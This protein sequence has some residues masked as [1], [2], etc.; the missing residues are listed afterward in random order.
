LVQGG[1]AF[2]AS[3]H[4]YLGGSKDR[5]NFWGI[6]SGVVDA[7]H[8][9]ADSGLLD[10][11]LPIDIALSDA[12]GPGNG[13]PFFG[14]AA[15]LADDPVGAD[16]QLPSE[17]W[18]ISATPKGGWAANA[19]DQTLFRLLIIVA[20]A[21]VLVPLLVAGRLM[22][23]RQS[24]IR[25]LGDREEQLETL[26]R[27]LGLALDTS[28]IGVWEYH[29][30]R[31]RLV[32]DDRM[33]ELYGLPSDGGPRNYGHWMKALHPDDLER[34]EQ[35]FAA[36][37]EAGGQYVSE[38]RVMMPGNKVRHIRAIG[39][40]Y[41]DAI[42]TSRIVGV[43][44]DV[45]ADF[46]LNAELKRVNSLTEARNVE[47][48][49]ATARIERNALHDAL[50]GLPNRR[51][52]D[53]VLEARSQ[54]SRVHGGCVALLHIDLDRFKQI[55]DTLG[56]AAGDAMLIHAAEVLRANVREDDFIGRIGGD[57]FVVVVN[58]LRK[59]PKYLAGLADRIITDMR[60]PVP[61]QGH[62]CRFGVSVGIAYQR[63]KVIDGKRLLVDADIALYRAKSQ[64][65]NRYEFFTDAL[66]AEIFNS[67]RIA[68]EILAGIENQEFVAYFQPQ[69][70]ANTLGICGVEAL[71]RWVHPTRGIVAPDVFL[72]IAEE[73]NVVAT[74]DRII[75]EQTLQQFSRW[76]A[77]GLGIPRAS[78]NVSARRLG[79]ENLIKSLQSLNIKPGTL[80]FE[81]V[82]SIYLD[83][84]D[85][86]VA[87]N[88]DHIKDLGI[89]IEI[90]DFGTGYA[91]I[92][93]LLKLRP[94]RLKIDRQ[95][96]IPIVESKAQTH[97]IAS[98]IEIGHSLGIGVVAEGVETPEH[99]RILK[100]LGC[101]VLQGYAFTR[102]LSADDLVQF[103][104]RAAWRAA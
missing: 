22:D 64:G 66:Q 68:D 34:A 25:E 15:V 92:V 88:I 50:T 5:S 9:Y 74:I 84:S 59:G 29:I 69:F 101:D 65:R 51:Y 30:E 103:V 17:L 99:T 45:S 44:W 87:W 10:P 23:E 40:F 24:H 85:A 93:S 3:F 7:H 11:D 97:L 79:D 82:E 53:Q 46:E 21:L 54:E 2:I 91:S 13:R 20:G 98:I 76:Q 33:N 37:L 83:E 49:A 14:D 95:L 55:N 43:N 94:R 16:V 28:E 62:E 71:A 19:P 60:R 80:S 26:S 4:V 90:D 18:H 104:H 12:D 38:Y 67:K 8:I 81:L 27:R 70:D 89:D 31:D 36:A 56:H 61:Y 47:L 75:L 58:L 102:P 32:W 41:F 100:G 6:V 86:I 35:E 42:G 63:G 72:P 52:L 78:V 77:M 1:Q 48:V 57:E 96:V 39:A 73:L